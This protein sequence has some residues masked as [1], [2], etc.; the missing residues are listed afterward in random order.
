[1]KG[2]FRYSCSSFLSS[3]LPSL[4][5][6]FGLCVYV[7]CMFGVVRWVCRVSCVIFFFTLCFNVAHVV[8]M[9]ECQIAWIRMRRRFTRRLIRIQAVC[10]WDYSCAWWTM[11]L[12]SYSI[13]VSSFLLWNSANYIL[14]SRNIFLFKYS[15]ITE[16][17]HIQIWIVIIN[18]FHSGVWCIS[19]LSWSK[20]PVFGPTICASRFELF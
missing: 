5:F 16:S 8:Q 20:N 7:W 19:T 4:Y 14:W 13:G 11:G 6:L 18:Q 10:I 3:S 9:S 12:K 1:M 17:D 2:L 15:T